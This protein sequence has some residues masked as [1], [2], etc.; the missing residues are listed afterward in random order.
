M[1]WYW[2]ES[3]YDE[4]NFTH[5]SENRGRRDIDCRLRDSEVKSDFRHP[6][7]EHHPV[8]TLQHTFARYS[9][10]RLAL[11]VRKG[12]YSHWENLTRKP[13]AVGNVITVI[14]FSWIHPG[15]PS[16][17]RR[18]RKLSQIDS[19]WVY[20]PKLEHN[21]ER[22]DKLVSGMSLQAAATWHRYF[23]QSGQCSA[24]SPCINASLWITK[25]FP[26]NQS[27]RTTKILVKNTVKSFS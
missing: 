13:H 4:R 11:T 7:L 27:T 26:P 22:H 12:R 10:K 15:M 20:P 6:L 19:P 2:R 14:T 25:A 18:G 16:A 23:F 17:H 24:W 5:G 3:H 21:Y 9:R 1:K 8:A